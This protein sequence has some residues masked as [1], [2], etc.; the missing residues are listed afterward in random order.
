MKIYLSV[1]MF[2][3]FTT[4]NTYAGSLKLTQRHAN[5]RRVQLEVDGQEKPHRIIEILRFNS[6]NTELH[7]LPD[8]I[9][10]SEVVA[11]AIDSAEGESIP[12]YTGLP[13]GK[14][15]TCYVP[16]GESSGYMNSSPR[17]NLVFLS[18]VHH[19]K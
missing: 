6:R 18:K 16:V 9:P 8:L 2:F 17:L 4:S 11:A 1:F 12:E 14:S 7:N 13:N 10:S 15:I 3:V 19:C 5:L